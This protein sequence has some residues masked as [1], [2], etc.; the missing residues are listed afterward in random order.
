MTAARR[1]GGA[2]A[3]FTLIETLVAL[4]ILGAALFAFY[5]FL[6]NALAA[7][8]RA[9]DAASIY[10]LDQNALALATHL[11]PMEQPEGTFDVGEYRIRWKAFP[12]GEVRRNTDYAG[13][14]GR[15]SVALYRVVLDF[16]DNPAVTAVE[17]TKLGYRPEPSGENAPQ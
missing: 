6:S 10:D 3:G 5:E 8:R 11:N 2:Q 12:I 13:A 4:V 14:P 15:F 16:P 9:Y 1:N 17:L 7:A